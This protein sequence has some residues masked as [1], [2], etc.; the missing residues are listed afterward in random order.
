MKLVLEN[1]PSSKIILDYICVTIAEDCSSSAQ[2]QFCVIPLP[3]SF[4]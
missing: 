2:N 4:H 1:E 3:T